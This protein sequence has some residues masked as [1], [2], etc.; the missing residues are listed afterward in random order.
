MIQDLFIS[1]LS[2]LIKLIESL[3]VAYGQGILFG[4]GLWTAGFVIARNKRVKILF[5][6]IMKEVRDEI[7]LSGTISRALKIQQDHSLSEIP[8][9][10]QDEMKGQMP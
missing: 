5:K 8:N 6:S 7:L 1:L 10:Y 9:K 4:L 2:D 3:I